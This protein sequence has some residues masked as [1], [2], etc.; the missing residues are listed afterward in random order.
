MMAKSAKQR[1]AV[2]DIIFAS[3]CVGSTAQLR[4]QAARSAVDRALE[5]G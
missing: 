5:P 1:L 4:M 3:E 2:S